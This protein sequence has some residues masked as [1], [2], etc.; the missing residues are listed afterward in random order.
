MEVHAHTHTPDPDSH[1]GRKK[2]I[3]YFWEFLMLFLLERRGVAS[4]Q[5][6]NNGFQPV[7]RKQK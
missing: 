6:S 1:R 7:A 4:V 3:H 5:Y 2:W